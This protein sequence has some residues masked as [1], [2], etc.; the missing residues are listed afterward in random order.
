VVLAPDPASYNQDHAAVADAVVSALRPGPESFRHQPSLVLGYEEVG[1]CWGSRRPADRDVFIEL[2]DVD[3]DRK[4]A[5]LALHESQW[6]E[7]P[8]TRSE[9]ALRALA[10]LRGAQSGFGYAEAFRCWRWR[11]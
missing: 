4:I 11:L 6:R 2:T 1:D 9:K 7:H 10:V 8:H 5:A 3:L